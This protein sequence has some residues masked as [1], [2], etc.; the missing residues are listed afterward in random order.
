MTGPLSLGYGTTIHVRVG[1]MAEIMFSQRSGPFTDFTDPE[2]V[3]GGCA[4][5]WIRHHE[6]IADAELGDQDAR[7]CRI[8][9]DLAPQI[10]HKDAQI[11]AVVDMLAA[12]NLAQHELM[13]DDIAGMLRQNL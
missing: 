9:L 6:A 11:V 10:A 3:C 8:G 2:T 13:G 1:V 5:R 4:C 7:L 12:P